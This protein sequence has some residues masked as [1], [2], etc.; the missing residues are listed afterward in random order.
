MEDGDNNAVKNATQ[1]SV[2]FPYSFIGAILILCF[3]FLSIFPLKTLYESISL[4]YVTIR[5]KA[6][7]LSP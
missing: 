1:I 4:C 6:K 2:M 7:S 5:S 3:Q